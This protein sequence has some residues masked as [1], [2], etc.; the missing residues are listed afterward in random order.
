LASDGTVWAWGGNWFGQVGDGTT[1]D[2]LSPVHLSLSNIIAVSAGHEHSMALQSDGTVLTWGDNCCG[3]LARS[4]PG[5]YS[6]APTATSWST[7]SITAI[8][9]G[10]EHSLVLK[11]DGSVWGAGGNFYG[12]LG[13]G[14][15]TTTPVQLP[16]VSTATGIAGG[17]VFSDILLA[18]GT[19]RGYGYG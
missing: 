6:T 17:G 8:S 4:T 5:R 19:V 13:S 1:T 10:S 12:E 11:S 15:S 2:A 16:N 7:G 14:G 9:A 3:Q 18:N